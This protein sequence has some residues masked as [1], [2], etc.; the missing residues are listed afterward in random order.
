M[1]F[2]AVE[3]ACLQ[4]SLRVGPRGVTPHQL[5]YGSPPSLQ[6]LRTVGCLVY[7]Y[8]YASGNSTM[9][10]DHAR[11]EP[12]VLVGFDSPSCSYKIYS[13]LTKRLRRSSEVVFRESTFPLKDPAQQVASQLDDEF[14][15]DLLVHG[16]RVGDAP[17]DLAQEHSRSDVSA[18]PTS[19]SVSSSVHPGASSPSASASPSPSPGPRVRVPPQR[20]DFS[21]DGLNYT[22]RRRA[23]ANAASAESPGIF[24]SIFSAFLSADDEAFMPPSVNYA[25]L[26]FSLSA[27]GYLGFDPQSF[28]QATECPEAAKWWT[29]MDA[30]M[31]GLDRLSAFTWVLL[32]AVPAGVRILSCKWVYKIKPEKY[33][34]R[35]VVCGDQQDLDDK[36]A[37]YSP[38]LKSITLRLLLALASY[39]GWSLWQMD[40]CNAFL[41]APLPDDT[42][43]PVFMYA[44]KGYERPEQVIRLRKALA[45]GLILSSR[46]FALSRSV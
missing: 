16:Q 31:F 40:V 28:K 7:Y 17:V 9:R 43:D 25:L 34:A 24:D 14:A 33:K 3:A 8:S 32:S 26:F 45:S 4:H 46:S 15:L 10:F 44:P 35:I 19:P 22:A 29:A 12:G 21:E 38:T 30:E 39:L 20:F 18:S 2:F 23:G 41:N 42:P 5:D 36:V 13:L 37:T 1:W 27:V 11:A 6:F